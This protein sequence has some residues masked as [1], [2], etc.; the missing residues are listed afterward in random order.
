VRYAGRVLPTDRAISISVDARYAASYAGQVC[1]LVSA[2]LLARMTP[3]LV[4]DVPDVVLVDPLPWAGAP[5]RDLALSVVQ[6]A[7][8]HG[9]FE[10]RRAGERDYRLH[11][12]RGPAE[13]T[14]H[15]SGWSAWVGPGTS[16]IPETGDAN[17]IGPSFA[18]VVA[19]ARLFGLD[20]QSGLG[21]PFLL[22]TLD[23][24][25]QLDA[26]VSSLR[27]GADFG[28]IW[29]VG[30]GSVGSAALYFLTLATRRFS[31]VTFDMDVV[32]VENLDRSPVFTALDAECGTYKSDAMTS[33]LRSVGVTQA[34]A[35]CAPL[36]QSTRWSSRAAGT[37]DLVI[38]AANERNVR[39]VIEQSCPPLQIYGTTGTNWV[40][41]VMRHIPL[42]DAC[43]CCIFPPTTQQA[44]MVCGG[45]RVPT[46]EA[47]EQIDV[48]L[49]FLSFGAGLMAAAEILKTVLPGYPFSPPSTVFSAWPSIDPRCTSFVPPRR[50]G[51]TCTER[52]A[53][54]HERMIRG[55]RYAHLSYR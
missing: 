20:M 34:E 10:T 17:P 46:S 23:W 15:G 31:S 33:Y 22:N 7:D 2:N 37:P 44:P 16:I 35:D 28:T 50:P 18:A 48:A 30:A 12:G 43:S 19:A 38:S 11:L 39:Y 14:V 1:T 36:D 26:Q 55:S 40:A 21:G 54:V 53:A 45:G 5:L 4:L 13:N 49:P 41:S 29:T 32:E 24:S 42:V 3:A 51:C 27:S 47:E 9:G 52:N 25:H 8:P 6:Q